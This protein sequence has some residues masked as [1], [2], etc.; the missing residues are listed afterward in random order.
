M[1]K[2]QNGNIEFSLS[3]SKDSWFKIT[4]IDTYDDA[5]EPILMSVGFMDHLLEHN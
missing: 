1:L 4:K 2:T 5:I 3:E